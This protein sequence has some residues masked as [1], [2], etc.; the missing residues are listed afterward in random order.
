[1][2]LSRNGR[3]LFY[4]SVRFSGTFRG[5][6]G[7]ARPNRSQFI[8]GFDAKSSYPTSGNLNPSSYYL[9]QK[10]GGLASYVSSQ[11]VISQ[12]VV[13][14]IPAQPMLADSTVF[15]TVTNAQLDQI[16]SAILN[17]SLLLTIADATLAGAA[18]AAGSS[19][20]TLTVN[21]ALCGAIFS[22]LADG[23]G[24]ITPAVTISALGNM[25]AEGGGATPLSPE[26]LAASLLDNEDIELGYS[27]RESIR[28]ILSASAGKL[29]GAETT[30]ITIRDINDT[31][32]R[33]VA[34]VDANG[35]RTSVSKNVS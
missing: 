23:A 17:G 30:T 32:N 28:L 14:L 10:A 3:S 1:M 7:E 9:P 24:V 16:V 12:Q 18:S 27:L 35:N 25:E 2:G 33:I 11:G 19:S 5:Q 15:L 13:S 29:S 22:V 8:G 4:G 6:V 20:C 34:T 31:V 26:G 21:S